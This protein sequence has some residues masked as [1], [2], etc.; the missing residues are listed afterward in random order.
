MTADSPKSHSLTDHRL[1]LDLDHVHDGFADHDHDFPDEGPLE[2]NPIW[3]QDRVTLTSVGIDIG[4]SGTQVIFSRVHMRRLGED[5]SSRYYVAARETLFAS[6][7]AL[8]PYESEHR[9]DE[10]ALSVII[11]PSL[12]AAGL[13]SADID[14]GVVILTGEALRRENAE[15]IAG[16]IADRG[17]RSRVRQ[18][19]ASHGSDA[20]RLR[21]R[22][23]AVSHERGPA[24]SQHRY[25]RWH[26]Q[27]RSGARRPR[28]RDRG[29]RIS[30]DDCWW[31]MTPV[32]SR[33][34]IRP[35]GSMR[36]ARVLPGTA[37]I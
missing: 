32:A 7:V 36:R 16:V 2:E 29:R 18:R 33:V 20:G 22:R 9:I 5:L 34:S 15:P 19:R 3:L 25:W 35:G 12:C 17:R 28:H 14:T 10:A 37:A 6:P 8:T 4:S 23:A 24:H 30:V 13:A 27:A 21:L 11:D 26:D 1:G 31:S